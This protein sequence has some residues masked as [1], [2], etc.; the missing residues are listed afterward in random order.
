MAR[1]Q[2]EQ[3]LA[4]SS[5][6][7]PLPSTQHHQTPD[8]TVQ[9]PY[10]QYQSPNQSPE[11]SPQQSPQQSSHQSLQQSTQQSMQHLPQQSSQHSPQHVSSPVQKLTQQ[12]RLRLQLEYLL[13]P[14]GGYP[15]NAGEVRKSLREAAKEAPWFSSAV[16]QLDIAIEE[17][18]KGRRGLPAVSQLAE[19][20]V[21]AMA[22]ALLR[23]HMGGA[24]APEGMV[25]VAMMAASEVKSAEELGAVEGPDGGLMGWQVVVAYLQS[26]TKAT[27]REQDALCKV[28][29]ECML[30][31]PRFRAEQMRRMGQLLNE[32]LRCGAS[33]VPSSE[34]SA[35]PLVG[36]GASGLSRGSAP[37]PSLGGAA[38]PRTSLGGQCGQP[39]PQTS[40]KA[41]IEADT[42]STATRKL[43]SKSGFRIDDSDD[44]EEEQSGRHGGDAGLKNSQASLASSTSGGMSKGSMNFAAGYKGGRESAPAAL[45]PGNAMVS[46]GSGTS[47]YKQ[48]QQQQLAAAG[49]PASDTGEV[50]G[51]CG[52]K[53]AK[54]GSMLSKLIRK[55]SAWALA[56]A[57]ESD[58][59]I[60][61]L[62]GY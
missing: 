22:L 41:R 9:L 60:A 49:S 29:A 57:A 24:G 58:D 43:R 10:S 7:P 5:A 53:D 17:Q 23:A 2:S 38:N 39:A 16:A 59:E 4:S 11:H 51:S 8:Q 36:I 62:D 28:C 55:D 56:S 13:K 44:S 3:Q 37:P 26:L 18:S 31:V 40:P 42:H 45:G 12:Q 15:C 30:P 25:M 6:M 47:A 34:S 21:L 46:P 52:K 27:P 32:V 14:L 35:P 48:R 50:V 61:D 54:E 19:P 33:P 20:Q 1:D